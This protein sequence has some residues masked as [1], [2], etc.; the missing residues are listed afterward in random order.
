LRHGKLTQ[1]L[2]TMAI[3]CAI[4][5]FFVCLNT[6]FLWAQLPSAPF[7]KPDTLLQEHFEED[8]T[9]FMDT[10]AT[11]FNV[12]WVN[13]DAD[14][15]PAE[16]N[17]PSSWYWDIDLFDTI[18]NNCLT[19]V[20]YLKSRV[21]SRNWLIL[22]PTYI[23]DSTYWLSWRSQPFEGPGFMDGYTVLVSTTQNNT[24][25]L[26]HFKDT[27]FTAAEVITVGQPSTDVDDFIFSKGYIHANRFTKSEYFALD[28]AIS[29]GGQL[30]MFY[31]CRLEPHEV[32][33]RKYANKTIY[34][35]FLHNS[36]NDYILQLD[37]IV[38]SNGETT[39]AQTAVSPIENVEIL[40]NPGE[41]YWQVRW[42][43]RQSMPHTVI[44][45][46]IHGRLIQQ[47]AFDRSEQ[48]NC[49]IE[50]RNLPPGCYFVQLQTPQGTASKRAIKH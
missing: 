41:E 26:T 15:I 22:P 18:S 29:P 49:Q 2:T 3:R 37:D 11:G 45:Y 36:F 43:L 20:S 39:A 40:G 12:N 34:I 32:S 28:S 7:P 16:E 9:A 35:A 42:Q 30:I 19:S 27:L 50:T 6:T 47:Q 5:C 4:F 38:I 23:P 1:I 25:N 31:R 48:G 46:D 10:I 17:K 14:K 8:V 21:R 33:L 13:F 24:G 44:L